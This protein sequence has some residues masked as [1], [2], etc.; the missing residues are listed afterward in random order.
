MPT[1]T[2]VSLVF[3]LLGGT[4]ALS[5]IKIAG[6]HSLEFG[7]LLN[8]DKALSVI[9]GYF[10]LRSYCFL[11]RYCGTIYRPPHIYIQL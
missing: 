2:T 9:S 1:S 11:F 3:E 5:I 10:R 7:Q 8:T 6:D 4:F